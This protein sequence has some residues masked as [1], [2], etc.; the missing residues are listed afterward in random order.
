MERT[1]EDMMVYLVSSWKRRGPSSKGK[2]SACSKSKTFKSP[3]IDFFR[4]WYMARAFCRALSSVRERDE[5]FRV[6]LQYQSHSKV[7]DIFLDSPN[8][9][10]NRG[11]DRRKSHSE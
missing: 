7:T 4:V 2:L 5:Q 8:P 10:R 11:T 9:I 3:V 6:E 1:R